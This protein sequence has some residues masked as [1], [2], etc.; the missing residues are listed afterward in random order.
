MP[1]KDWML[2]SLASQ[3]HIPGAFREMAATRDTR[4]HHSRTA[5]ATTRA[6]A[7]AAPTHTAV[8]A[9]SLQAGPNVK[10][11]ACVTHEPKR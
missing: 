8:A 6:T 4:R 5:H 7:A 9:A 2:L 3:H 11:H 1:N 10:S